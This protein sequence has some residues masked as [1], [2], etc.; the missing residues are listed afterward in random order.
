MEL[1]PQDGNKDSLLGPKPILV[2][3]MDPPGSLSALFSVAL[4]EL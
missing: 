1:G 4:V 3:Y 2:V